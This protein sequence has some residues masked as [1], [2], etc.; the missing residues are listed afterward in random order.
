MAYKPKVITVPEGGTGDSSLT[1]YTPLCGGTTSTGNVQSISSLGSSGNVLLSNGAGAL[2]TFQ[3][4]SSGGTVVQSSALSANPSDG[5]TY[6]FQPGFL[7][8]STW[9]GTSTALQRISMP[10]TGTVKQSIGAF[11]VGGTLGSSESVVLKLYKNDVFSENIKTIT[12]DAAT[13]SITNTSL[14]TSVTAGDFLTVVMANPT[15]VTNP[16]TV[17][18]S[19]TLVIS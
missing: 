15:W 9:S 17:S 18:V 14:S 3:S 4:V 6:A 1:A 5:S 8:T 12:L 7:L 16:T 10:V 13:V 19:I 2:P 11:T